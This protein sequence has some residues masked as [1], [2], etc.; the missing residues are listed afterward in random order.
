MAPGKIQRSA[1]LH[2]HAYAEAAVRFTPEERID[3]TVN[4]SISVLT[5]MVKA[6]MPSPALENECVPPAFPRIAARCPSRRP[7]AR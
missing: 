6:M 7:V 4:G 1:A 2:H 5:M 3:F